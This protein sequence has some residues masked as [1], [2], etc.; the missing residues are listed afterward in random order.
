MRGWAWAAAALLAAGCAGTTAE[1]SDL[2]PS[3]TAPATTTDAAGSPLV[4]S[5]GNRTAPAVT[6]GALTRVADG[7]VT[8]ESLPAWNG[9][10]R[11][12]RVE[13]RLSGSPGSSVFLYQPLP[14]VPR[15]RTLAL[16]VVVEGRMETGDGPGVF[17]LLPPSY[18]IDTE[19][20]GPDAFAQPLAYALAPPGRSAPVFLARSPTLAQA[21]GS[22][23]PGFFW[24]AGGNRAWDVTL[25]MTLRQVAGPT[26][27]PSNFR[28]SSGYTGT[29]AQWPAN[30][31]PAAAQDVRRLTLNATGVGWSAAQ[32]TT[33]TTALANQVGSAN[34]CTATW[35]TGEQTGAGPGTL[36]SWSPRHYPDGNGTVLLSCTWNGVSAPRAAVAAHMPVPDKAVPDGV[37]LR[38]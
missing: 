30:D 7:P 9:D 32:V 26:V 17:A 38:F 5:Q 19:D 2:A 15:D 20:G 4:P 12:G 25:T 11:W 34:Q 6:Q 36:V 3:A 14:V 31:P 35:A 13:A 21:E 27:G 16:D 23:V 28:A 10:G 18:A 37:T 33:N 29:W 24:A 22:T 1:T 8:L